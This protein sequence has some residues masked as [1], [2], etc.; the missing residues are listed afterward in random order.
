LEEKITIGASGKLVKDSSVLASS[1][2]DAGLDFIEVFEAVLPAAFCAEFIRTFEAHSAVHDGRTGGG[3]D[4]AKKRSRDLTFDA[5][6]ELH[7]MLARLQPYT[8]AHL[9]RYFRRY[10]FAL[11]GALSP[12]LR[13]P[14]TGE[15]FAVDIETFAALDDSQLFTL[16]KTI[17]RS[18]IVNLQRYDRNE[19]GYPYW[20]SEIYPEDTRCDPLHRVLFYMYYLN[21][22]EE[23]GETEFYF[24][25]RSIQ[26]RRGTLVVAP[27]GFTHTHRGNVPRSSD[28]YI[29]TSWLM[30]RRSEELFRER[31]PK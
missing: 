7:E 1:A 30:F 17:Y 27:A 28:K 21:D 14:Q 9:A 3:V 23:G 2:V 4:R 18:G 25:K 24:Q 20:H 10:P 29:L 16:I 11:I 5:H 6:P 22:V 12:T 19:G 15:P 26:P 31:A 13:N 8:L